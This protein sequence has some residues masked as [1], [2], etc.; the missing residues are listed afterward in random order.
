[1]KSIDI[2]GLTKDGVDREILEVQQELNRIDRERI[3]PPNLEYTTPLFPQVEFRS[4]DEILA[5]AFGDQ[6]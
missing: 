2:R 1:M 3:N 6:G 4:R 5:R